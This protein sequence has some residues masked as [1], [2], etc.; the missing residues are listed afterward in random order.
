MKLAKDLTASG[1]ALLLLSSTSLGDLLITEVV[2]GP[3]IGGQPKW[4]ELTNT[5]T[6]V[7]TCL[8]VCA[9]DNRAIVDWDPTIGT[10]AA[11]V[12]WGRDANGY[13]APVDL[14]G[15]APW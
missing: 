13:I 6:A 7:A 12:G 2:D 4:A 10:A 15:S 11:E 1:I 9:G 5:G 14:L 3:L 8:V